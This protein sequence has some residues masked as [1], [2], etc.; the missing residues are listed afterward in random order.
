MTNCTCIFIIIIAY[1]KE[2]Y[3]DNIYIVGFFSITGYC[4][5]KTED[6]F[7]TLFC[8][9]EQVQSIHFTL[10]FYDINFIRYTIFLD[11]L[12]STFD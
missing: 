11:A 9:R 10:E 12:S 1:G 7:F 8:E 5:F 4:Y 6:L 3:H 2:M